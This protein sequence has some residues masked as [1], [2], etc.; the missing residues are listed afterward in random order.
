MHLNVQ[1]INVRLSQCARCSANDCYEQH[2][3][4]NHVNINTISFHFGFIYKKKYY[5]SDAAVLPYNQ[6][7]AW[8][9]KNLTHVSCK[10]ISGI[11][12][13]RHSSW[14]L[15]ASLKKIPRG[16]PEIP[17][18]LFQKN[19][20]TFLIIYVIQGKQVAKHLTNEQL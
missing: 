18:I 12:G 11:N 19:A 20:F 4:D 5:K 2:F 6:T 1:P 7:C 16:F 17:L 13:K 9:K 10:F 3:S 14:C 8:S 15:A